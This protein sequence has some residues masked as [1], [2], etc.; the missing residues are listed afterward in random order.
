MMASKD[1]KRKY[2]DGAEEEAEEVSS[3][4]QKMI[5]DDNDDQRLF[6]GA[7]GG[8]ETPG[9]LRREAFDPVRPLQ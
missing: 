8:N 7:R 9:W 4:K 1:N 3:K 5:D 2:A 6:I